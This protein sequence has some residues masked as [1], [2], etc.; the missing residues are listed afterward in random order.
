MF[1]LSQYS[2]LFAIVQ[3]SV[4]MKTPRRGMLQHP[5]GVAQRTQVLDELK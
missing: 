4:T 3:E 1:T 2:R 5:A